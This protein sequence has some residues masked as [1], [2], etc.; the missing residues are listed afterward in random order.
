MSSA[1]LRVRRATGTGVVAAAGAR[2]TRKAFCLAWRRPRQ[3]CKGTRAAATPAAVLVLALRRPRPPPWRTR[4]IT[5]LGSTLCPRS[6]PPWSLRCMPHRQ[7]V[8]CLTFT[9]GEHPRVLRASPTTAAKATNPVEEKHLLAMAMAT[10]DLVA[11]PRL[12]LP[13]RVPQAE[14]RK[15]EA[16]AITTASATTPANRVLAS[17]AT[18]PSGT[19]RPIRASRTSFA[20]FG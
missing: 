11:V 13:V 10:G 17:P 4:A 6:P 3:S 12:S 14:E 2:A 18:R 15:V 1:L 5:A 19:G 9:L 20:S 16:A 7:A 8:L